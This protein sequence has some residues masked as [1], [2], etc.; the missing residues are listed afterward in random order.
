MVGL[1]LGVFDFCH[2]GHLNLLRRAAGMCDRLV[3][4]VHTDEEVRRY[5]GVQPA[6]S[7]LERAAAVRA[8]GIAHTVVVGS[9]RARLCR[10]H[11]VKLVFHGD[12]WD[13]AAYRRRWGEELI[14]RLG[15]ELVLLPHTPGIDS[16]RLRAAVPDVGWWLYSSRPEWS[17]THIFDH[18][19]DL[20]ARIGG[21][22]F[23]GEGGRELVRRHF[24][25]APCALLREDQ[26]AAAAAASIAHYRL[27]RDRHR[28]LQF[29][30][31]GAGAARFAAADRAG[32]A[33]ARAQRQAGHE[34]RRG[35]PARG[36]C[37]RRDRD[38]RE[39]Q[40]DRPRLVVRARR[41]PALRRVPAR[42][43]LVHEPAAGR[44]AADPAAADLG[45]PRRK[46]RSADV[47]PLARTAATAGPRRGPRARTAPA[48]LA[49]GRDALRACDRRP[50]AARGR[51]VVR[52][53]G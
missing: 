20:Y 32:R 43:R 10:E 16:T 12:D 23:V 38:G 30:R 51:P 46:A 44:P 22:W 33:L 39:R 35:P 52:P 2:E 36:A 21:V 13:P 1:T 40:P 5:K 18:L 34:R 37:G 19:R 24:P 49:A 31:H 25:D 41:L 15:L 7:E 29:R 53:R 45:P 11:R 17:R 50:D 48:V 3:V 8:L 47:S 4:G 6:N 14:A 9:D 26:E 42:R 28:P 27:G